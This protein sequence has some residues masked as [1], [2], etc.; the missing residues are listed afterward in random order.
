MKGGLKML[1]SH[2]SHKRQGKL[3]NEKCTAAQK[4]ERPKGKAIA[5]KH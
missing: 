3:N 5:G 1:S 4:E 2:S